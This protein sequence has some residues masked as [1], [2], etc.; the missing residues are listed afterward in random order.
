MDV[1]SLSKKNDG[2]KFLL[3]AI[4]V[5]SKYLFVRPLKMKTGKEVKAALE[6]VF[7][8][9][10]KPKRC[11]FDQGKEFSN[12][13]VHGL[14]KDKDIAYFTSQNE[15]KANYAERVIKTLKKTIYR[16]ITHN[17]DERYIDRLQD[18]VRS[19]N[20]SY[21]RTIG[22]PPE[23]V[24]KNNERS[25]WWFS[26]WRKQGE[27]FSLKPFKFKVGDHVRVSSLKGI[28]DREYD[29]KWSGKIFIVKNRYRRD[30]INVYRLK[31][32]MDEDIKGGFYE[33]ELQ[34]VKVDDENKLWK[35]SKVLKTRKNKGRK[36]HLVRWLHW[37]KK[38]D[39]WVPDKDLKSL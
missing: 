23:M 34:K 2:V 37:P 33:V 3:V 6:E 11:R 35:I 14:L 20:S 8:K 31:D 9:G 38:F 39:S 30:G 19:Y 27:Y 15:M 7:E 17:D 13:W 5:F 36:E 1:R 12:K 21:H 32:F 26:Y 10:R 18:F 24:G 16:Y 25:V 28:F 29:F 22:M 4:D